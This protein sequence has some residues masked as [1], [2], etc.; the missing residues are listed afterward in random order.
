MALLGRGG[1]S[2]KVRWE[3]ETN[4]VDGQGR[5]PAQGAREGAPITPFGTGGV[6]TLG[7]GS[8]WAAAHTPRQEILGQNL[9][10]GAFSGQV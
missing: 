10:R 1:N 6:L 8:L 7:W 4:R 5:V 9:H 3:P 2:G